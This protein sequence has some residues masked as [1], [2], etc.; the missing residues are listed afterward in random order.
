MNND[1]TTS[2]ARNGASWL[3]LPAALIAILSAPQALADSGFYAGGSIGSATIAA[4]IPIDEINDTLNFDEDDFAWKAFGGFNFDLAVIDLGIEAGYVDLGAPS[5]AVLDESITLDVTGLT[6]FGLAG[7]NLGPIGVFAKAGM[8]NWD[9]EL[10]VSG[11]GEVASDDGSDPAYGIGARFNLGSLQI[12]GE[13]EMFDLDDTDD[14]YMLS[15]GLA[16][17]F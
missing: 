16:F 13:Y 10:S 15:L 5:F 8:I 2:E 3:L 14:V 17:N 6:L 9:A 4:D 12:R 1:V 11:F 7:F